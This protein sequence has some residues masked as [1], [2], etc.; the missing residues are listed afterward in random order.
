MRTCSAALLY[1]FQVSLLLVILSHSCYLLKQLFKVLLPVKPVFFLEIVLIR[2][3]L[4]QVLG[5]AG[6]RFV[7]C[8]GAGLGTLFSELLLCGGA[9]PSSL[10]GAHGAAAAPPEGTPSSWRQP[11]PFRGAH[12]VC[13]VLHSS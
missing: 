7:R 3:L 2:V 13:G 11:K 10:P 1:S 9:A 8:R 12:C 6:R 5:R 4:G